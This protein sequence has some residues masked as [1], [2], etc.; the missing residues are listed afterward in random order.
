MKSFDDFVASAPPVGPLLPLVHMTDGYCMRLIMDG[1]KLEAQ[2]C[3][4]LGDIAL[5][6][7]YGRPAFRPHGGA[8]PTALSSYAPVCF[9]INSGAIKVKKAYPF[10]S[11]AFYRKMFSRATHSKMTLKN[12]ELAAD[13]ARPQQVVAK[14]FG[15]NTAYFDNDTRKDVAGPALLFEVESFIALLGDKQSEEYDERISSIEVITDTSVLLGGNVIA[16][17]FPGQFSDDPT[18][19]NAFSAL[20]CDP[21][22]YSLGGRFTGEG[23][24]ARISDF[25]RDYLV[26]KKF[27]AGP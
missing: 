21:I 20:G 3:K 24:F 8:P 7:S 6:F 26:K 25:V 5:Y 1:N 15:S 17:A 11:G 4:V 12:F 10:D 13:L 22:P 16:M 23:S 14:F 18:F 27:L 19:K 9:I 2:A